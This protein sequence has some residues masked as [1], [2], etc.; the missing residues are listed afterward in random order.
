MKQTQ[1]SAECGG[2][3]HFP[4]APGIDLRLGW[5]SVFSIVTELTGGKI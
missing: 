2:E 4:L 1:Q 5:S 3:I